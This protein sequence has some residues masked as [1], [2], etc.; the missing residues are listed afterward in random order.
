M[1]ADVLRRFERFYESV[2]PAREEIKKTRRQGLVEGVSDRA[3]RDGYIAC[4]QCGSLM[5]RR[6]YRKISNVIVDECLGHGV[7]FDAEEL[8]S[9]IGFLK[10]GGMTESRDYE[11]SAAKR[12]RGVSGGIPDRESFPIHMII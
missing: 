2:R 10:A 5:S 6:R 8:E 9:A 11:K 7:W 4:P 12:R 1:P 3:P